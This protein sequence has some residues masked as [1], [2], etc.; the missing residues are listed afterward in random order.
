[1]VHFMQKDNIDSGTYVEM[2]IYNAKTEAL[3][4]KM[5]T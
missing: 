1:M 2:I 5:N 4:F 3:L